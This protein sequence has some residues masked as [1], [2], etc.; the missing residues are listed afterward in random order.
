M[1]KEV[2]PA[3]NNFDLNYTTYSS[4]NYEIL[5]TTPAFNLILPNISPSDYTV[6]CDVE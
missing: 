1:T 6:I 3:Y 5:K 4:G 2:S